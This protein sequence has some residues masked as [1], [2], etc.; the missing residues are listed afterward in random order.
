M[1]STWRAAIAEIVN[2]TTVSSISDPAT[3]QSNYA[4]IEALQATIGGFD[5]LTTA[6]DL[7]TR[8]GNGYKLARGTA[9]QF[10]DGHQR[11]RSC[12]R[13]RRSTYPQQERPAS[14]PRNKGGFTWQVSAALGANVPIG[15]TN[16]G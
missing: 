15:T 13:R 16:T 7:L 12:G 14:L 9:G 10:Y 8:D 3:E 5:K 2:R 4:L 11:R 6:G 1:R